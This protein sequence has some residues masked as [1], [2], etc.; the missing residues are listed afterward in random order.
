MDESVYFV[1]S[2]NWILNVALRLWILTVGY[3]R[4]VFLILKRAEQMC[5]RYLLQTN[6]VL[7]A[8][9]FFQ[10]LPTYLK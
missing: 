1:V 9:V 3:Q 10:I 8:L 7:I 6:I 5:L 2:L 4:E